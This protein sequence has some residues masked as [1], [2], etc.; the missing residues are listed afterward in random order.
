MEFPEQHVSDDGNCDAK[1]CLLWKPLLT[2]C[3]SLLLVRM[4]IH[5]LHCHLSCSAIHGIWLMFLTQARFGKG[6]CIA[7]R[8]LNIRQAI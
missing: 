4:W 1:T 5:F 7:R 2:L 3:H 8:G 6:S